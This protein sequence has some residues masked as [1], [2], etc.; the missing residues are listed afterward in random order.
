M[1]ISLGCVYQ[2]A[3]TVP[4][5]LFTHFARVAQLS[6]AP[7]VLRREEWSRA[8]SLRFSMPWIQRGW[9]P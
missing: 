5:L 9:A 1:L 6:S 3:Q 4:K 2:K 7:S 8:H